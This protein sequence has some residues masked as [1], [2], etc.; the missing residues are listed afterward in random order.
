MECASRCRKEAAVEVLADLFMTYSKELTV[1]KWGRAF[2]ITYAQAVRAAER[3]IKTQYNA[4]KYWLMALGYVYQER[5]RRWLLQAKLPA[6]L[7]Q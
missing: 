1:A 3:Y 6:P 4:A 2:Q 7:V 5:E